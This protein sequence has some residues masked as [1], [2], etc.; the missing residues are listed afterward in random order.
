MENRP[1]EELDSILSGTAPEDIGSY[2]HDNAKFMANGRK[3][4]YYYYKDVLDE[5]NIRLKDVYTQAGV[6]ES[7]GSKIITM[8]KHTRN[9]DLIIRL[10]IAGHFNIDEINRSLK[11]YGFNELYSKNPKDACIIVSVNNRIYDF[12]KID[13]LLADNGLPPLSS[14]I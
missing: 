12:D 4:F 6:T 3:V 9:R 2:I 10:C 13:G 11:L 7:Y 5:K 14:V 8:E 1:T